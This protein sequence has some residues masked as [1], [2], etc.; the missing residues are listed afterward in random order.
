MSGYKD[1]ILDVA[2]RIAVL[3][4]N[5]PDTRNSISGQNTIEEIV[6]A[7]KRVQND[8][9]V[10]VLIITGAGKSFSSG[11]NVKAMRERANEMEGPAIHLQERYRRGIQR[12]PLAIDALDVPVIGAINGHAIGA[13]CDLAMMCDIRIASRQAVFG[14]TFLNLGIIPGDGGSW[15]LV[16]QI[17][18]QKSAE[19]TFTGRIVDAEEALALGMVLR[20][21]E[22]E[23]LMP[24]V[25]ALA[26]VIA[27]KPP[28]TLRLSKRILK[29]AQRTTLSDFLDICAVTQAIAQTTD[30]H[31]I[32][33]EAFFEKTT[34]VFKGQ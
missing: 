30:D 3:T 16:R 32:A 23:S 27:A 31:K 20:V 1:I 25:R 4:L 24:E 18:Y 26:E 15:F 11:G 8:D 34:P 6:D 29:Q 22:H 2:D 17:G 5:M 19:L 9:G 13:G 7:C 14:E 12:I 33:M 10:S 28:R 21:V